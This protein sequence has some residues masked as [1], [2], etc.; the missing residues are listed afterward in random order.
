MFEAS[1]AVL[2][3]FP[4]ETKGTTRYSNQVSIKDNQERHLDGGSFGILI[5][6]Q[7]A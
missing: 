3:S 5:A 4:K 7:V 2:Y 1:V 6:H